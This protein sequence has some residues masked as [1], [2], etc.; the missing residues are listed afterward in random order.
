MVANLIYKNQKFYNLTVVELS[1]EPPLY[2]YA[3][4]FIYYNTLSFNYLS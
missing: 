3:K 1:V 4:G 2:A